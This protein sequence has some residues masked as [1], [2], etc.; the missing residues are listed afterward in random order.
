MMAQEPQRR[1]SV[2]RRFDSVAIKKIDTDA[3]V[4]PSSFENEGGHLK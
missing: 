3:Y 4:E 2:D 1:G